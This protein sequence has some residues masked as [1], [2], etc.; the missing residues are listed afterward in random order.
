MRRIAWLHEHLPKPVWDNLAT[1]SIIG[2]IAVLI[3]FGVSVVSLSN[4]NQQR[5]D[6]IQTSRVQSC[7][8]TYE[9][10]RQ[11]FHPFFVP[12]AQETRKQRADQA[13]FNRVVDRLKAKCDKQVA[14]RKP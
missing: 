3:W 8:Q 10:V 13:K 7:E 1:V 11:V 5:I 2:L 14:T 12:E 4:Q 6:D 9:G